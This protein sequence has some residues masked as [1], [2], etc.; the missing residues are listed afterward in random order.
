MQG[1]CFD[2]GQAQQTVRELIARCI[3]SSTNMLTAHCSAPTAGHVV[4]RPEGVRFRFDGE[5]G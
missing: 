1:P 4:W 3:D 5:S 2:K